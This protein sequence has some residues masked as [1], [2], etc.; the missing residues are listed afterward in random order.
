[1]TRIDTKGARVFG[2]TSSGVNLPIRVDDDGNSLGIVV[3]SGL[4]AEVGFGDVS[5]TTTSTDTALVRFSGTTGKLIQD[6]DVILTDSES[7]TGVSDFK[8]SGTISGATLIAEDGSSNTKIAGN[9]LITFVGGDGTITVD[10]SS[11]NLTLNPGSS[12]GFLRIGVPTGR[13]ILPVNTGI[14]IGT[15]GNPFGSIFLSSEASGATFT[16]ASGSIT[17]I[18]KDTNLTQNSDSNLSTQKAV[19]AYVDSQVSAEDFWDRI[20]SDTIIAKTNTD[21]ISGANLNIDGKISGAGNLDISG[22]TALAGAVAIGLTTPI[23]SK[24]HIRG[25]TVIAERNSLQAVIVRSFVNSELGSFMQIE[26]ARGT[27]ASP[28]DVNVGDSIGQFLFRARVQNSFI[29]VG[30]VECTIASITGSN[31]GG[32]LIFLTRTSAG[33]EQE[34]FRATEAKEVIISG[35]TQ[36]S[37]GLTVVGTLTATT[38][39][40]HDIERADSTTN[41]LRSVFNIRARSTGDMVDGF[42]PV[43]SFQIEDDTSGIKGNASISAPRSGSDFRQDLDFRLRTSA[44]M[45]SGLNLT[46]NGATVDGTFANDLLVTNDLTVSGTITTADKIIHKDDTDTFISFTD[47]KINF[48]AGGVDFMDISEGVVDAIFVKADIGFGG[49]LGNARF[50]PTGDLILNSYT[51]A[52]RPSPATAGKIIFNTDDGFINIDNGSDWTTALG[53]NT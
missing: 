23:A 15:V 48:Q 5:G 9:R 46:T 18:S 26:K 20:N 40:V 2:Q 17:K 43:L 6:S 3:I 27:I 45:T 28:L 53:V 38:G 51:D 42:G 13:S 25:G 49:S 1:M 24:L 41:A 47:D 22:T 7:M 33:E 44:G 34:V 16:I 8:A 30:A 29:S 35:A 32:N 19:K 52:T 14:D 50:D 12:S 31:A 10:S 37:G 4:A 39:G 36:I 11:S 21:Q